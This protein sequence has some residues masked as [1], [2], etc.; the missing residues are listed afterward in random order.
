MVAPA[1]LA[2][3]WLIAGLLTLPARRRTG[4]RGRPCSDSGARRSQ[5][6]V[7]REPRFRSR[8]DGSE[9]L[10][11][12]GPGAE[13]QRAPESPRRLRVLLE[14]GGERGD[15]APRGGGPAA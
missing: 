14:V 2:R 11:G 4:W 10:S 6:A 13:W 1:R 8:R 15:R 7:P 3:P 5:A 12:P 9:L